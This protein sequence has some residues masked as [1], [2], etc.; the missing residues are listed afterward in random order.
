[1]PRLVVVVAVP[2]HKVHWAVAEFIGGQINT[3]PPIAAS[4]GIAIDDDDDDDDVVVVHVGG[5]SH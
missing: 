5:D 1:M 2:I 4:F 3:P